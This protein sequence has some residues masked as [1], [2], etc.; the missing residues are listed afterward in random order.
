MLHQLAR[1]HVPLARRIVDM[2]ARAFGHLAPVTPPA[3]R[4]SFDQSAGDATQAPPPPPGMD[5]PTPT[6]PPTTPA[7]CNPTAGVV[8]AM[9][10][11]VDAGESSLSATYAQWVRTPKGLS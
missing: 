7:R 8:D 3:P 2:A 1:R 5:P 11:P 6:A 10:A 9:D 4:Y